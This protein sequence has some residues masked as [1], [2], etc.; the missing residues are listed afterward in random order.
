MD[1]FP[2]DMEVSQI[3]NVMCWLIAELGLSVGDVMP[4]DDY[5][6]Y[7]ASRI[8]GAYDLCVKRDV[9]EQIKL[10]S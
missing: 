10:N 6:K 5:L 8:D 3:A 2:D 9:E 4:K 1:V 7:I